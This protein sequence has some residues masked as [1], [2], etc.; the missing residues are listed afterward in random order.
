MTENIIKKT[1]KEQGLTYAQLG[2]LIGYGADTLRNTAQKEEVSEP[3]TKAIELY[4]ETVHLKKELE[5]TNTLKLILKE[6]TK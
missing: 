5:N 1:C 3:M 2:D 4:I 6:F